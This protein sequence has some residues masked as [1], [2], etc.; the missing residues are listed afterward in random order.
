MDFDR[1]FRVKGIKVKVKQKNGCM[2]KI[3]NCVNC[4]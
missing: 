2:G 4:F 1:V 3:T